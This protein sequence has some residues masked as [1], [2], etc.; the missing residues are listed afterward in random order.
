MIK[1][2]NIAISCFKNNALSI[3]VRFL[4]NI[5]TVTFVLVTVGKAVVAKACGEVEMKG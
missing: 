5:L 1:C 4:N 2:L 3:F